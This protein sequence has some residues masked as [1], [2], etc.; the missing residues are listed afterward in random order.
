MKY[1]WWFSPYSSTECYSAKYLNLN[2]TNLKL[3]SLLPVQKELNEVQIYL[4]KVVG[5]VQTDQTNEWKNYPYFI[6][7]MTINL[8]NNL[9]MHECTLQLYLPISTNSIHT[10]ILHSLFFNLFYICICALCNGQ[11]F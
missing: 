5:E 8:F 4:K 1:W 2:T 9:F 6:Y 7:A 10:K 11:T 3:I